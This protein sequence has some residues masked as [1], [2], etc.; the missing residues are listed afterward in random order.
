MEERKKLGPIGV[1]GLVLLLLIL[2]LACY[3]SAGL[4]DLSLGLGPW[5]RLQHR[6]TVLVSGDRL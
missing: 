4:N 6:R 1:I 3:L 5:G 2:A